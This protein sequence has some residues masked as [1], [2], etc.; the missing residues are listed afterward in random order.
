V[1]ATLAWAVGAHAQLVTSDEPAGVLVFPKIV[2]DPTGVLT[3]GIGVDTV[4]QISNVDA[5]T[6]HSLHCF[7]INAN[8]C[9]SLPGVPCPTQGRVIC[10]PDAG[11]PNPACPTGQVCVPSWTDGGD[12]PIEVTAGQ[13]LGFLASDPYPG[14]LPCDG[15]DGCNPDPQDGVIFGVNEVPFRGELKCIEVE[16]STDPTVIVPIEG[17]HFS[18]TARIYNASAAGAGSLDV[19]EYNAIGIQSV[20]T[21]DAGDVPEVLCLGTDGSSDCPAPDYATC[22]ATLIVDHFFDG[23]FPFGDGDQVRTNVT[24]VPCTEVLEGDATDQIRTVVQASIYNEFEQRFSSSLR[25]EC[26]ESTSLADIDTRPGIDDDAT[27][28]FWVGVQGTLTGQTR[29]RGVPGNQP[30][31]GIL[32]VAEELYSNGFSTAFNVHNDGATRPSDAG[33]VIR[34]P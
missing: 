10:D 16:D 31:H 32:A 13:P 21:F 23:A 20:D 9:C 11:I 8:A 26:F 7:W 33:D 3:G 22:P 14:G 12:F 27:S 18:G 28:V 6:P 25:L 1:A 15:D 2:V 4:V 30:Y 34:L 17:N 24:L 19:R 29:L 5:T